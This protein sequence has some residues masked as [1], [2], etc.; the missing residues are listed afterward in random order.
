MQPGVP[1]ED[2]P[3]GLA[4]AFAG[5]APLVEARPLGSGLIHRTCLC[6][7]A[8]GGGDVRYV[9][10]RINTRVFGDP[11]A[12]MENIRRVTGHLRHRLSAQGV[13]DLERR[14]L[15]LVPA[16]DGA[17]FWRDPH[18]GCWRTY[19]YIAH[20]RT[21][22][23][24]PDPAVARAA[25]RAYGAFVRALADL[26]GPS[27]HE[28]IPGFH[29]TVARRDALLRV[30]AADPVNRA[31]NVRSEIDFILA[32]E[33]T[34]SA[35]ASARLPVRV[36]HNDTKINNVLFDE[37]SGQ[38]LCVLDLD[39]VMPGLVLHDFGDLA[40]SAAAGPED[41]AAGGL[42]LPYFQALVEGYLEGAG[43]VLTA[44]ELDRLALAP[45]VITLE[46]AMRFLTDDLAGDVYFKV[47]RE[48]HNLE[49]CRAQLRLLADMENAEQAMRDIVRPLRRDS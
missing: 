26:P 8:V 36:V 24:A 40:R 34:A 11:A 10:Q 12:L 48:R 38:A 25:A 23:V 2:L 41:S 9:H 1:T 21:H 35:L 46:L 7:Y 43:D 5:G 27:L 30:V 31:R 15:T 47:A 19:L 29:D 3:Q 33:S 37:L 28:T 16:G 17:P 42:R 14:V 18:G 32:R 39:T 4:A 49:R 44:E 20:A 45:R 22:D 6:T 13:P